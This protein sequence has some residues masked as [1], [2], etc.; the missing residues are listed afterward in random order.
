[1]FLVRK[2]PWDMKSS[3]HNLFIS[4]AYVVEEKTGLKMDI[5]LFTNAMGRF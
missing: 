5:Q 1:M 4:L 2:Q 3:G